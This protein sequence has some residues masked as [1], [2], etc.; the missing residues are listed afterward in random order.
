MTHPNKPDWIGWTPPNT[1]PSNYPTRTVKSDGGTVLRW[2]GYQYD[3]SNDWWSKALNDRVVE[4]LVVPDDL[5]VTW[6]MSV[7]VPELQRRL[8]LKVFVDVL[9]D[10]KIGEHMV[11]F[12][13][14][15]DSGD[16]STF[17][18]AVVQAAAKWILEDA[19]RVN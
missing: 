12:D 6:V 8:G 9:P 15:D 14:R 2:M 3:V 7:L 16:A 1:P 10:D 17:E 19:N 5:D 4:H 13:D 18:A 11:S